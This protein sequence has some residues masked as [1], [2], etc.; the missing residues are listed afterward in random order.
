MNA[1]QPK[2]KTQHS[3]ID[4]LTCT[5]KKKSTGFDWFDCFNRYQREVEKVTGV[6]PM[7]KEASRR[8]YVGRSG[9]GMFFGTHPN[10][11]YMLVAWGAAAD[12]VWPM[13]CP[14]AKNITRVDLAVTVELA[15]K[16]PYLALNGYTANQRPGKRQYALIQNTRNGRTL[17]VGSR[18]SD[19]FGR[20]Y[21]KG[22]KD[23]GLSPGT[24]WRYEIELKNKSVNQQLMKRL[25]DRWR[26]HGV[27]NEDILSYVHQWF[28]VRG[29]SP[30]FSA[31][32]RGLPRPELEA[33][34][35][36]AEKKLRWLSAQVAPTVQKLIDLG[37]GDEA[38]LALGLEAEQ[39]PFWSA[40]VVD[41][42]VVKND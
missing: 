40:N 39:L 23:Y 1:E 16:D 28:S 9:E 5:S 7:I 38:M 21:D 12:M 27:A 6:P 42:K 32:G 37:L 18:S 22:V 41:G 10:Q 30:K 11:G 2:V 33:T 8:G 20:L 31:M 19:Q 29:V 35:T 34:V 13:S 4:W 17:Y 26:L 25:V 14:V 3:T 24:V 15:R 36:S